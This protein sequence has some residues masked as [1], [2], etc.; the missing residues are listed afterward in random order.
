M[1]EGKKQKIKY[2]LIKDTSIASTSKVED[3]YGKG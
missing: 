1:R 3:R 2:V